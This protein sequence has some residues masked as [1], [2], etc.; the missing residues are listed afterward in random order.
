MRPRVFF[1]TSGSLTIVFLL[2]F[3]LPTVQ[4]PMGANVSC[5]DLLQG[6]LSG[7]A[8]R[9]LRILLL[10]SVALTL[11]ALGLSLMWFL[12]QAKVGRLSK[13]GAIG[14]HVLAISIAIYVIVATR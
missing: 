11:I 8:W 13:D 7:G 2:L 6:A 9:P 14:L 1:A 12:R 4:L 10:L 5:L 3:A